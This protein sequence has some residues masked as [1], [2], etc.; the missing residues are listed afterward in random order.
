MRGCVTAFAKRRLVTFAHGIHKDLQIRSMVT[1]YGGMSE[2]AFKATVCVRD[3]IKDFL[4]LEA[5]EDVCET[6]PKLSS[7][8]EGEEYTQFGFSALSQN[9]T[10]LAISAGIFTSTDYMAKTYHYL[11]S[12]GT[13]HMLFFYII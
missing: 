5:S 11:G 8:H 3:D 10:P 6:P 1:V 12:A 7:P 2:K 13:L 4:I 9:N